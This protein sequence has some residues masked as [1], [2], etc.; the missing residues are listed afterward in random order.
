MPNT[1]KL[2]ARTDRSTLLQKDVIAPVFLKSDAVYTDVSTQVTSDAVNARVSDAVIASVTDPV[3]ATPLIDPANLEVNVADIKLYKP[4]LSILLS[5]VTPSTD[6]TPRSAITV[7][8][9]LTADVSDEQ[10]FEAPGDPAKKYYLPRYRLLEITTTAGKQFG[11]SLKQTGE[12]GRLEIQLEKYPVASI[13]TGAGTASEMVHVTAVLLQF[14]VSMQ[15]GGV[16]QKEL[17]LTEISNIPNGVL[18]ALKLNSLTQFSQ[19]YQAMT[20]SS[21]NARLIVRRVMTVA[22]PVIIPPPE[23]TG[24][25]PPVYWKIRSHT[26]RYNS[27]AIVVTSDPGA[28][29]PQ[30]QTLYRETSRSLDVSLDFTFPPAIHGYMF[31]D[32]VTGNTSDGPGLVP[33]QVGLHRYYQDMVQ[34]GVFY[35]L[36]DRFKLVR[37]PAPS[38]APFMCVTFSGDGSLDKTRVTFE[39]V[40]VPFTDSNRIKEAESK[41]EQASG[42]GSDIQFLPLIAHATLELALPGADGGLAG[43]F[44]ERAGALVELREGIHDSITLSLRNFQLLYEALMGASQTL[45]TGQ[46]IVSVTDKD[47]IQIPFSARLNDLSGE[48]CTVKRK[49]DPVAGK[50]YITIHN[51]IESAVTIHGMQVA[52]SEDGV[53]V[54]FS[55]EG[56]DPKEWLTVLPGKDAVL[57]LIPTDSSMAG[58]ALD[59]NAILWDIETQ[60]DKEAIWYTILNPYTPV[61]Y[62]RTISVETFPELFAADPQG[63]TDS[64]VK[65]IVVTFKNGNSVTLKPAELKAGATVNVSLSNYILGKEDTRD[66]KF[67]IEVVTIAGKRR[68]GA[69]DAW[70]TEHSDELFITKDLIV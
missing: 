69:A 29:S 4:E 50:G 33:H 24:I 28:A 54:P 14:D 6:G 66:Y 10:F 3:V 68:T 23:N 25:V 20:E 59:I 51:E 44:Q 31:K 60:P 42:S 8:V 61:E 5:N 34:P 43:P 40:A 2:S 11:I 37:R 65:A 53:P 58:R 70:V 35:Y 57:T 16:M 9:S 18:A 41:L 1:A 32:I 36:P 13:E 17:P 48:V 30:D 67:Q 56:A 7:P 21:Y 46:V 26:G 52:L 45:F 39:Y 49:Y 19:V 63:T 55:S 27:G 64:A 15:G 12:G 38:Y 62:E 47:H 22:L